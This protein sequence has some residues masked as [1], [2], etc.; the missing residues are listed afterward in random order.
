MTDE[1]VYGPSLRESGFA[2]H[3]LGFPRGRLTPNGLRRLWRLIIDSKP[4]AVQTWMYHADLVG[5]L[6]ARLA[7]TRSVIW[8]I[9]NSHTSPEGLSRSARRAAYLC[10]RLSNW[11][12]WAII[13]CSKHA[14]LVHQRL[15][16]QANKI[17]IIPNGY[18]LQRFSPRRRAAVALRREWDVDRRVPVLGMVAR[19]DPQKDHANLLAAAARLARGGRDFRCV[20]VGR[21]MERNNHTLWQLISALGLAGKLILLGI[22]RQ[23]G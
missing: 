1:G 16:Y 10:A 7:G 17:S 19:W 14:A 12:P 6:T 22:A 3:A 4:D 2:V 20:L 11:L 15:G 13:S 8:G 21:G 23:S 5:G 9:R 18:D